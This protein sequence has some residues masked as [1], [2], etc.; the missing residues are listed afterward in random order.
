[1]ASL[2]EDIQSED[3]RYKT[4]LKEACLKVE[5]EHDPEEVQQALAELA[6][7]SKQRQREIFKAHRAAYV[8]E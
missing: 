6:E 7:Q 3:L 2:I 5:E 1:M 4:E 8:N